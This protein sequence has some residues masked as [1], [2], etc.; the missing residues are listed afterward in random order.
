MSG[1]QSP[2]LVPG[3]G[4]N[5]FAKVHK[6][7]SLRTCGY[8][9]RAPRRYPRQENNCF[10]YSWP[11]PAPSAGRPP[12]I[13]RRARGTSSSDCF[14]GVGEACRVFSYMPRRSP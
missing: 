14:G 2:T 11:T 8:F 9:S 3:T 7:S 12:A 1:C 4:L 5:L 6:T 13:A 10:P